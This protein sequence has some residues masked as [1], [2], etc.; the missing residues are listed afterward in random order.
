MSN[1]SYRNILVPYDNSKFSQ[2]ALDVAKTFAKRF[3]CTLHIATVVDISDVASP[4]MIRSKGKK[5]IDQIRTS[6]KQSAKI[7]ILQKENE[8]TAEKIKTKVWILEGPTTSEL[9]RLIKENDI[10][11][12]IV[13]SRGL[14]GFSK[15]MA[16]GSVSRKISE[17]ADCPVMVMH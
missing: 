4:G 7:I 14:S 9:L 12:V 6:I 8:C 3:D 17:L 15:F 10:D 1:N 16:L 11:L 2:K 13:G 5:T